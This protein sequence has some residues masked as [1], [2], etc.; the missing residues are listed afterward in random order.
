MRKLIGAV[1]L[2][3][4]A[5][6][7]TSMSSGDAAAA[8]FEALMAG[9]EARANELA[10]VPFSCDAAVAGVQGGVRP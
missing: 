2:L 8:Y 1:L 4:V 9:D 10:T 7:C 3:V 6:S 5:T